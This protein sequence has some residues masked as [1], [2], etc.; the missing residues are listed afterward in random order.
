MKIF[1][2]FILLFLTTFSVFGTA[3]TPDKI[4]YNGKTYSLH[5]NPLESYFKQYP[6]KRPK[7]GIVSSGLWRGYVATFEI[8]DN[9]L[10]LKDIEI[11]ISKK[12]EKGDDKDS[13]KSVL[14]IDDKYSWKSVLKEV[15]PNQEFIKIDWMTGLLVL[16]SGQMVNYVHMGYGS[17][18]EHYTLLEIENG[19]LTK[20][21]QFDYEQYE[22]F[23]ERQFQAFKKTEEYEKM[24]TDFKKRGDA[25]DEFID[26]FLRSYII[27][28]TSKIL[29]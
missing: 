27:E 6:D 13:W 19:N 12:D 7:D 29:E 24:K 22:E 3:Q 2:T 28:Y 10:Y 1:N 11:E 5:S 25:D 16:P 23:K 26:Y 18:F 20:E 17:T 14:I 4:I 15:F 21:K 9:Q 8:I